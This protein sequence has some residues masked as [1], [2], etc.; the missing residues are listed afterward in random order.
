MLLSE[1]P[2]SFVVR[3]AGLFLSRQ[4]CISVLKSRR[5][6]KKYYLLP[7]C[8]TIFS[9][10]SLS[11]QK[12]TFLW[13]SY[14]VFLCARNRKTVFEN[15]NNDLGEFYYLRKKNSPRS[16]LSF[17]QTVFLFLAHRNTLYSSQKVTSYF[18]KPAA[19]KYSI[20]LVE[21]CIIQH[22]S[23]YVV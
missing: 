21:K 14:R 2:H 17:S 19:G 7:K 3:L 20:T 9:V 13:A 1:S 22:I 16:L 8:S 11:K 10:S 23:R 12:I 5:F 18:S 6:V 4:F 15:D